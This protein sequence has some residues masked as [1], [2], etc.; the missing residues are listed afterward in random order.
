MFLWRDLRKYVVDSLM[1]SYNSSVAQIQ[2][3]TYAEFALRDFGFEIHVSS[4]AQY[5]YS[6]YKNNFCTF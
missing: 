4:F 3:R 5:S 1:G 2:G 6:S